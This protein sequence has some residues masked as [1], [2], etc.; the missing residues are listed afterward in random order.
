MQGR[1]GQGQGKEPWDRTSSDPN[2]AQ[3]GTGKQRAIPRRPP[4]MARL[5]TPPSTPR[6]ARPQRQT[7]PPRSRGRR[8]LIF[9]GALVICG[10]VAFIIAYGLANYFIGIGSSAG[11]AN[12]AADFLSNVQSKNYEQAY[13]DLDATLTIS[14]HPNDFTSM[15]QAD[16]RCYGPVTD[17]NEVA[18]SATTSAD[19]NTQS[20]TYTMTRSK[21]S[22]V[23]QLKLTIQKDSDGTWDI[24]DFGGDLGPAP[25]PSTC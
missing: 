14:L 21:L 18:G 12:T 23:Y 20:Y 10:I 24:T 9:V 17:Y 6:V 15:A 16:D 2:A 4:G 13:K 8:L 3:N 25:P 22:K 11:A 1:Y 19:G 5:D 7:K